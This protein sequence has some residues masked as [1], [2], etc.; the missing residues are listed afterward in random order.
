MPRFGETKD[1]PRITDEHILTEQHLALYLMNLIHFRE[2]LRYVPNFRNETFVVAVDGEVAEGAN[3]GKLILDI[4]VLRSLSINVI[5]VHGIETQI[6]KCA[7]DRGV[8]LSDYDGTGATDDVSMKVAATAAS[9]TAQAILGAFRAASLPAV[10]PNA[11]LARPAGVLEGIDTQHSGKVLRTDASMLASLL[12]QQLIPIISPL[13]HDHQGVPFRLNSDALAIAVAVATKARK[14]IFAGALDGV[15]IGEKLLRQMTVYQTETLL[16]ESE[17]QLSAPVVSKLRQASIACRSGIDRVH[18]INGTTEEGL[19]AEVFS[20]EGIGTLVY[21]DE[22]Q[23]IRAATSGDVPFIF[24]LVHNAATDDEVIARTELDIEEKLA[25]HFV[26][27]VD[28]N[29]VAC[30]ALHFYP[31]L[32]KAELA[33]LVVAEGHQNSGLAAR[34][35]KFV[36]REAARR[37]VQVLFCLS[38]Q[39]FGYFKREALF[40]DGTSDDLPE[41]R[42]KAWAENGRNSRILVKQ[43][44]PSSD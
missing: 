28:G 39:A 34:L 1:D 29:L 14:V 21:S 40:E 32:G 17:D 13:A 24:S 23:S 33:S 26:A 16:D 41:D 35:I 15:T 30:V 42:R 25:D 8:E 9:E 6:Q 2:I 44:V 18:I 4:G 11:I 37:Q 27:E 12:G 5:V 7:Q 22:Y 19:L 31:D 38:T 3:F 36:E 20:N 43:L 10:S